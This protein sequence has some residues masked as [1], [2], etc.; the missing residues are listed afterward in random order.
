MCLLE[1]SLF[2]QSGDN[3]QLYVKLL[4]SDYETVEWLWDW[5]T[6][7]TCSSEMPLPEILL[8]CQ[9]M[10]SVKTVERIHNME[11]GRVLPRVAVQGD[12]AAALIGCPCSKWPGRALRSMWG[13]RMRGYGQQVEM[14][15]RASAYACWSARQQQVLGA[16]D[17]ITKLLFSCSPD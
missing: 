12:G 11:F 13:V 17:V 10:H 3:F 8:W 14:R 2:A 5:T 9:L 15:Q 4:L 16:S 1:W 7:F 6:R